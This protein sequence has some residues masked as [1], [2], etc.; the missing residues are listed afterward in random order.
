[1]LKSKFKYNDLKTI[2]K[3]CSKYKRGLYCS[4]LFSILNTLLVCI[5]PR[6][7][8][9]VVNSIQDSIVSGLVISDLKKRIIVIICVCLASYLFALLQ[10]RLIARIT[11]SVSGDLRH[12]VIGKINTISMKSYN[13]D[14]NGEILSLISNDVDLIGQALNQSVSTFISAVFLFVGSLIMMFIES[15]ILTVFTFLSTLAGLMLMYII[16]KRTQR[17]FKLQQD[18]I[19]EIN[20]IVDETYSGADTVKLYN[21]ERSFID[22]FSKVNKSIRSCSWKA[23][24]FSGMMM[25]LMAFV[26]NLGYVAVC[27]AGGML[28]FKG[29]IKLGV[30]VAFMLY[31]KNFTEPLSQISQAVSNFQQ[32]AAASMRVSGFLKKDNVSKNT[33]QEDSSKIYQGMIEFD[34]VYFGYSDDKLLFNKLS[35]KIEPGQQVA[36]VG[37]TG[38][39]KT[40]ISNLLLRFYDISS[41]RIL[42]DDA[43]LKS[44]S[45][46]NIHKIFS[47]VS[48]DIWLFE[49][50]V[51]E[52][53]AYGKDDL[54]EDKVIELCKR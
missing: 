30:I 18:F 54:D 36:F 5:T 43:D 52:N 44:I 13:M 34:N 7:I 35:F 49:G 19:A 21:A 53:I 32:A 45:R 2:L 25:P 37:H 16:V 22:K 42:I 41:G 31:I 46:K 4:V 38:S 11:Q 51:T 29:I 1:M 17:Y 27:I 3:L 48:Q 24:Y 23:Q 39:G 28:V 12:S 40:T 26:A 15:R 33:A 20:G 50:T 10:G 6:L 9:D 14:R 47:F 8:S